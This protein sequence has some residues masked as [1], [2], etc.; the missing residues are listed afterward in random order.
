MCQ[1]Q[2]YS[3]NN[4]LNQ[5]DWN[6]VAKHHPWRNLQIQ[7]REQK[8]NNQ[9]D[10]EGQENKNIGGWEREEK[11]PDLHHDYSR[12]DWSVLWLT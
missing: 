7:R 11:W 5:T 10:K 3:W 6:N 12:Y 1:S 9:E 2:C 4:C 8:E